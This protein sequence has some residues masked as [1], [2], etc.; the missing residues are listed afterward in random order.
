MLTDEQRARR[1]GKVTASFVPA[2][3]AGDERRMLAEW[4]RL[5]DHPDYVEEDLSENWSVE[6]GSYIEPF[7]LD[8]HVQRTGYP[9][10]LRGD[11]VWHSEHS[12]LGA[13]LDAW[14]EHDSTVIDCKAPGAYRNLDEV[15][16][17]YAPQ[18][19]VQ[20]A[21]LNADRAAL[22]I[23]HGGAEPVEY[24]A[25]W[26]AAYEA[27]VWER[28][29]WFWQ[30]VETLQ[31]PCA[32][33]AVKGPV[34]AIRTVDMTGSNAWAQGAAEWLGHQAAAGRFNDSVKILKSLIEPDVMKA[35]GHGISATRS[36]AGAI[37][38]KEGP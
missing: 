9:L 38:I 5:V 27:Q 4:M 23:V 34:P 7:A 1:A 2:L 13:T 22:L 37:S 24:E 15:R 31:P 16:A 11:W 29:H 3:M 36:R 12:W 20:R 35:F 33:P 26:D 8:W 25:T 17:Y 14:R 10:T 19:L 30:R 32:I 21:C 28:I 6:F 18:L